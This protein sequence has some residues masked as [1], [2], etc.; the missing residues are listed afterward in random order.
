MIIKK[1]QKKC[2]SCLQKFEPVRP[3]QICCSMNCAINHNEVK[4]KRQ[5]K[6]DLSIAR[7]AL[8]T[9]AEHLKDTQA[10]FN[11]FIRLRDAGQV[12]I[13]CQKP[14]LKK[15]NAG[16][17]L[18]VGAHPELRFNENN[19]NAQCEH[20]NSFLSGNIARY[21]INLINKIGREAVEELESYHKPVKYTV[22]EILAIKALYR[23]K[24][25]ELERLAA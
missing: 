25:K 20:C 15:Q 16:H 4:K 5:L 24:I 3:L 9:R 10:V 13:S 1:R 11:R 21:R 22:E 12:C 23:T 7:R 18:S 14:M 2:K 17:Y 6:H 19:N 8:K